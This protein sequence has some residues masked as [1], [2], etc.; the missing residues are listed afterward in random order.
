[1][2]YPL[3][4]AG[5]RSRAQGEIAAKEVERLR[6]DLDTTKTALDARCDLAIKPLNA[7]LHTMPL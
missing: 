2:Y 6:S 4:S 7:C 5:H 1:L 3:L